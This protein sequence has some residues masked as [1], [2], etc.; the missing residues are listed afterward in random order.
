MLKD[1]FISNGYPEKLVL[2]TFEQSWTTETLKAV[3]VGVQ[4][5]IKTENEK[6][7]S[8]VIRAPYV[9]GFSEHLGRKLR[10]LKVGYVPKRGET[11]YT[12]MC[13]LKQ[14]VELEDYKNVVYAVECETCG[15]QYIGETGQH[16]CDRRNQHQRDIRQ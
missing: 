8:D 10:R 12:N 7:Y 3:L 13:R 2:Q 4:Q 16:F 5:E 9:R 15:V 1:V 14:K 6:E 11:L